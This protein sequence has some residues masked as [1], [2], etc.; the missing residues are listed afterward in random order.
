MPAALT[1]VAGVLLPLL[2]L[3]PPLPVM[4]F[5]LQD[6]CLPFKQLTHAAAGA[7]ARSSATCWARGWLAAAALP[8][9]QHLLLSMVFPRQQSYSS[10]ASGCSCSSCCLLLLLL[11]VTAVQTSSKALF[12]FSWRLLLQLLLLVWQWHDLTARPAGTG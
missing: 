4:Q 12:K 6:G 11:L 3:L 1:P 7:A 2:L 10:S 8:G 5:C 9:Q